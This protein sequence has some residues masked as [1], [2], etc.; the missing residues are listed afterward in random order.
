M[1]LIDSITSPSTF[2]FLHL[3]VKTNTAY[4]LLFKRVLMIT[5]E[6]RISGAFILLLKTFQISFGAFVFI[7]W[8]SSLLYTDING[9]TAA[10]LTAYSCHFSLNENK[11]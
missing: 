8:Y 1:E 7:I 2:Y 5:G 3:N 4:T 10:K 11:G 9:G 6:A